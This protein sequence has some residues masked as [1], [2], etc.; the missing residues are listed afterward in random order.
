M[1]FPSFTIAWHLPAHWHGLS[2][3]QGCGGV[4]CGVGGV[5]LRV[6]D[7]VG[8]GVGGD[9]AGVGAGVGLGVGAGEG[10][11]VGLGFHTRVNPALQHQNSPEGAALAVSHLEAVDCP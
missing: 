5:G 4:G 2:L 9:G 3:L 8:D 10:A 7:G 11:V 1:R 6:G